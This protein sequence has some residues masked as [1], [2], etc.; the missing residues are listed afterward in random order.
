MA[1]GD[2]GGAAAP[3]RRRPERA[4][5]PVRV[6]AAPGDERAPAPV[7]IWSVLEAVRVLEPLWI[8][9]TA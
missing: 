2:G 1:G 5:A 7:G 8:G 9:V 6:E 3:G 4:P